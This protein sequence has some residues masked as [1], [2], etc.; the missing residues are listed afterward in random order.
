MGRRRTRFRSDALDSAGLVRELDRLADIKRVEGRIPI[1]GFVALV[2]RFV[3]EKR[4]ERKVLWEKEE[5][6]RKNYSSFTPQERVEFLSILYD[7]FA[8]R[9]DEHMHETGHYNAIRRVMLFAMPFIR[10]PIMDLSAGTGEPLLYSLELMEYF[11]QLQNG[12]LRSMFPKIPYPKTGLDCTA[13]ANEV[14]PKMLERAKAKLDRGGMAF[15]SHD[16]YR[17]PSRLMGGFNTV[18]CSQTFHIIADEDKPRMAHAIKDALAPGGVAI[19]IEEDPFLIS[20]SDAI[21]A[22]GLF[23]RAIVRPV[24]MER[25]VGQ[26]GAVGLVRLNE[27]ATAPI[28]EHHIM[29]L[30][31]FMKPE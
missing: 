10:P 8:E 15:S 23:L 12:P 28:D 22:V 31:L 6:I 1:A 27:T 26:I 13:H 7:R 20:Q 17:M 3:D 14:S 21:D 24:R 2:D 25:L 18:L 16:A 9:Y 30:H 5:L 29:R 19:V 4:A 11:E